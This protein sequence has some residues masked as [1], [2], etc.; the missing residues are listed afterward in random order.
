MTLALLDIPTLET[1]R[2]RLRAPKPEDF[3]AYAAFRV[4]DRARYVGGPYSRDEAVLQF[5]ELTDHWQ[6]RGYGRWLVAD[7]ETDA[8]LGV[9]G[10]FF[11]DDWPEPEIAWAVFEAAEGRGVALEAARAARAYAYDTLGWTTV[12]S[13]IVDGND[14]SV[15]LARRL[16]ARYERDFVHPELGA[17]QIWRHPGPEEAAA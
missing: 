4:S 1:G 17:M 12:I 10:L 5:A 3:E 7:P 14:R 8:P 11:P 9:V 16:G 2:L 6:K 15:R 13:M